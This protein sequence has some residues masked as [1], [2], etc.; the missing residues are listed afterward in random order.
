MIGMRSPENI[1]KNT[2]QIIETHK[3]N[4][5]LE[6]LPDEENIGPNILIEG[7]KSKI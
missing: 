6:E 4:K 1:T 3:W 2:E 5:D 7:W